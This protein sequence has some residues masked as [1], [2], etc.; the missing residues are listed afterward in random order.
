MKLIDTPSEWKKAKEEILKKLG[1]VFTAG[2]IDSGKTTLAFYLIKEAVQRDLKVALVD[3]DIGQ[4]TIGPP[5]TIGLKFF[6]HFK[7]LENLKPDYLHFVGDTSPRFRPL[8]MIAGTKKLVEKAEENAPDLI[9]ID[10]CGFISSPLGL[11][12]K[13]Q[14]IS[15]IKPDFVVL[16]NHYEEIAAIEKTLRKYNYHLV[17]LPSSP[18]ARLTSMEERKKNREKAFRNYF[19]KANELILNPNTLSIYPDMF[20][21]IKS[22]TDL[23]FHLVGLLNYYQECLGIGIITGVDFKKSEIKVFT[24]VKELNKICGFNLGA[25]KITPEGKELSSNNSSKF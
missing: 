1:K 5:T 22:Q 18:K 19:K 10:S 21:L 15:L 3:S 11:N 14:K 9:I 24:P 12:L 2:K 6:N 23:T 13:L 4:S 25:V 7:D 16:F 20:T 8:E 17:K